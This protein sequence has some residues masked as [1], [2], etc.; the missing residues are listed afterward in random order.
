MIYKSDIMPPKKSLIK[1][2]VQINE[3]KLSLN[4]SPLFYQSNRFSVKTGRSKSLKVPDATIT[5][6]FDILR[7]WV[8]K[9]IN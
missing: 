6:V 3:E 4:L 5:Q 2:T 8:V 7:R 9:R 1:I